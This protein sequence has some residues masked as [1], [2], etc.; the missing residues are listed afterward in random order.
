MHD[1]LDILKNIKKVY[2]QDMSVRLL[3][4]F[5]RV[6]D[7][8]DLYVYA[9]WENGELV[10]GPIEDRHTVSAK[11]M[12]PKYQ[13]PDPDVGKRLLDYGIKITFKEDILLK[14]REI[15]DVSDFRPGT[16]KAK[17][18]QYPIWIVDIIMPKKLISDFALKGDKDAEAEKNAIVQ[19]EAQEPAPTPATTP[20]GGGD[21]LGIE[22]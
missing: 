4:D 15:K 20:E 22:I 21:D 11:F 10:E 12:C 5:E 18:D 16:R 13:M 6:L 2:T 1:I 8:L 9:N 7:D 19:P 14:P 17:M 3:T